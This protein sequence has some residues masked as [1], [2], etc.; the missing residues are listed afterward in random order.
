MY[1]LIYLNQKVYTC[2]SRIQCSSRF[3]LG[4]E[5][6]LGR[7]RAPLSTLFYHLHNIIDHFKMFDYIITLTILHLV[8]LISYLISFVRAEFQPYT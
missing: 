5:F 3:A 4:Q 6:A 7:G 1:N 8:Y 2:F